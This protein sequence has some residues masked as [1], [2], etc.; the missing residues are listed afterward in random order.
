V[1]LP[2][3]LTQR[4]LQLLLK[5]MPLQLRVEAEDLDNMVPQTAAAV[6]I[7]LVLLLSLMH[8]VVMQV[9]ALKL[10]RV[11]VMVVMEQE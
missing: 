3:F 6:D 4:P 5:Q 8:M 11:Q 2:V 9:A 7:L 1:G 10:V